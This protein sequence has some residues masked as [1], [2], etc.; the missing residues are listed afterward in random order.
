[1][2]LA[3]RKV[4][5]PSLPCCESLSR[6]LANFP[7]WAFLKTVP[8]ITNSHSLGE[9]QVPKSFGTIRTCAGAVQ[10]T[11]PRSIPP[12]VAGRDHA[13]EPAIFRSGNCIPAV[14][15]PPA[16]ESAH[17]HS[18]ARF[19]ILHLEPAQNVHHRSGVPP[20]CGSRRR[21]SRYCRTREVHVLREQFHL[22]QR[23]RFR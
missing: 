21:H 13:W 18:G 6:T 5:P 20:A 7:R 11:P 15:T 16:D 10:G 17:L 12:A 4:L 22:R 9:A 14:H 19:A 8:G 3:K 1:M 23:G 2:D